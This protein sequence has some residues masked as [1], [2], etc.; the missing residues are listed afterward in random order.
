M[1]NFIYDASVSS[2]VVVFS[3]WQFVKGMKSY[4]TG[5]HL[6]GRVKT[7]SEILRGSRTARANKMS[8][9][10]TNLMWPK[11]KKRSEIEKTR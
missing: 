6:S 4:L 2:T 5:K 8:T 11:K 1:E 3:E 10:D 9:S 7:S